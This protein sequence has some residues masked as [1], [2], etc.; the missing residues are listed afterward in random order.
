MT[1]FNIPNSI[2]LIRI[3]VTPIIIFLTFNNQLVIVCILIFIS[4]FSD[5]L[6]GY[7]ARRFN[8]FSRLGELLD[9]ISDRIYILT[10]LFIVYYINALNILIIGIIILRELFMTILIAYL[11]TKNITGLPVHYLGKMGAFNLLIGIPGL[12][13]AK[14][15]PSQEFI[16]LTI[17]WSF[18]LWGVFLYFFSTI[19]YVS[20]A[21]SILKNHG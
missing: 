7:I 3:A 15:F 20:Q 9:P 2:T 16:W 19:K 8:Q 13:F 11:K 1:I 17:G 10:L 5:W 21:R 6:D 4:S 18:L 12:I 14:A